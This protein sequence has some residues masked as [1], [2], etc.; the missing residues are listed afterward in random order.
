MVKATAV[1]KFEK[2]QQVQLVSG[3]PAMVVN[4]IYEPDSS[5]KDV[6]Y[7][8]KWFAGANVK[9]A[10]FSEPTLKAFAAPASK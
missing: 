10:N 7:S 6:F 1:P 5:E 3:G 8:C 4:T 2:G 9:S